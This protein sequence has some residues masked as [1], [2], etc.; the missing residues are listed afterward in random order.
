MN[1]RKWEVVKTDEETVQLEAEGTDL[2]PTEENASGLTVESLHAMIVELQGT[3]AN[4]QAVADQ[5]TPV[6][7]AAEE[8]A[9]EE[10]AP[11]D[12][13]ALLEDSEPEGAEPKEEDL[14]EID[15]LLQAT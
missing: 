7:P 1:G 2:K 12:D 9:A 5:A 6:E 3:V 8:V 4:L 13:S 15:A 14:E 11:A 10:E